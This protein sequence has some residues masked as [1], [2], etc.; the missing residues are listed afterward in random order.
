MLYPQ[1]PHVGFLAIILGNY[2]LRVRSIS[3]GYFIPLAW[4]IMYGMFLGTNSFSLPLAKPMAPTFAVFGR[5]G[6]YE[7]AAAVLLAVATNS[8]SANRSETFRSSSTRVPKQERN[9]LK[10]E[11]WI[12]VAVSI[13]I[14]AAAALREAYMVMQA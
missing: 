1:I 14:L 10:P 4:M 9:S 12:A 5:S 8:I 3:F 6:L 2:I 11:Q 13:L 7:M